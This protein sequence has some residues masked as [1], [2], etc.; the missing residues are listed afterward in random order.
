MLLFVG[1]WFGVKE[2]LKLGDGVQMQRVR[3]LAEIREFRSGRNG[4]RVGQMNRRL[5]GELLAPRLNCQ[6]IRRCFGDDFFPHRRMNSYRLQSTVAPGEA[7]SS[8][9]RLEENPTYG[10]HPKHSGTPQPR[11]ENYASGRETQQVL[12]I[13]KEGSQGH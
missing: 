11:L 7:A 13:S 6:R 12:G 8:R 2:G 9:K 1:E 4:G 3:E 5:G 10:I